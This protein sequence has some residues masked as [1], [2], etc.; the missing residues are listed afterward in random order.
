MK[1][2]RVLVTAG[3]AGIGRSFVDTFVK[4]GA[5]VHACDIDTKALDEL[6]KAESSVTTTVCDVSDLAQVDR[7]FDDAEKNLR[8]LDVLINNAGITGPTF[9]KVE[10]IKPEDWERTM[11]VN[12]NGQFFC[13]RRAV[14]MLKKAGGGS[15][16]NMSSSAGRLG[17]PLRTA[18][19]AS[20]WAVVGF[21]QSLAMELGP[22]NIR[23][24]CIQPGFVDGPRSR[25]L[26]EAQAAALGET[27]EQCE[28][29]MFAKT[30]MRQRVSPDEIAAMALF[31]ASDA[32]AHITGQ[33]LAVCGGVETLR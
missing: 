25:R 23:V 29:R 17:Y 13:V 2:K 26:R 5:K 31:L 8:G 27:V 4:A 33:S 21:T 10:E 3:A 22:E 11:Q 28:A 9:T 6:R 16:V 15:I 14:P 32:G 20:K 30:S 19:A 12:I 1:Q 24:N 18:Y 7:L